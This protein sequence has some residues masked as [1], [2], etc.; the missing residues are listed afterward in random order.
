MTDSELQ[1]E[2][3]LISYLLRASF[4]YRQRRWWPSLLNVLQGSVATALEWEERAAWGIDESA[5]EHI[6]SGGINPGLAF[7]HP[8]VL[9]QYP[10]LGTYY[11]SLAL[12][13]RKGLA[14]LGGGNAT[15]EGRPDARLTRRRTVDFTRVVNTFICQLVL[16]DPDWNLEEARA[17]ALLNLGSQINGSWRNQ[18]GIE[19]TRRVKELV[20]A[21]LR[22]RGAIAEIRGAGSR[23]VV[24]KRRPGRMCD[25]SS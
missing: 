21:L 22:A 17:A 14:R 12:L 1:V 6:N 18:I 13:P 9:Q 16:G 15:F 4:Y 20:L 8:A 23:L 11:R 7:C 19:G 24:R 3:E 2:A 10:K 25:K 5:W